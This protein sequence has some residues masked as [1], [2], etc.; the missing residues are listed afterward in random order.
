MKNISLALNAI[1]T[2]AVAV[3]FYLHFSLKSSCNNPEDAEPK[4]EK[5]KVDIS[6]LKASRIMYVHFD[7]LSD[8]Y[9]LQQESV[10][11]LEEKQRSYEAQLASKQKQLEQE[12]MKA[13]EEAKYMTDIQRAQIGAELQKKEQELYQL[14]ERYSNSFAEEMSN[15]DKKI[16]EEINAFLDEYKQDREIDYILN[17]AVVLYANDSLDV[18][19]EILEG[20]NRRYNDQ[21]NK[22]KEAKK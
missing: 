13:Q 12:F 7:T 14:Q 8:K 19:D 15:L 2:I 17:Y 21:K 9:E 10:K 16:K 11:K 20:L 4:K 1:L 22:E 18:T 5:Q 6:S 3:L